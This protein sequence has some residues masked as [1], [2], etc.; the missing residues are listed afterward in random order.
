MYLTS[1]FGDTRSPPVLEIVETLVS[2]RKLFITKLMTPIEEEMS[3][4]TELA[5]I[6]EKLAKT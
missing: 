6:S 1:T 2:L 3:R 4:E 5:A